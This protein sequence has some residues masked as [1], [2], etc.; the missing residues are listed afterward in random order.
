MSIQLLSAVEFRQKLA[1][2]VDPNL[3]LPEEEREEVK[4]TAIRFTSILASLFGE[5]L[6]RKTLWERIGN[7]I[8]VCCAKCGGDWEAFV[9]EILQYIKADGGRVAASRPLEA[10]LSEIEGKPRAWKESFLRVLETKH[11]IIVVK[12]RALWNSAKRLPAETE[13]VEQIAADGFV[14]EI[15]EAGK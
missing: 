6:D 15:P 1:G 11:F 8:V 12:A 5:D 2:L 13:I 10:M 7:G 3:V 4:Q 14:D 9:N